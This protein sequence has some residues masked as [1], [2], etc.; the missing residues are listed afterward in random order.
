MAVGTERCTR[1]TPPSLNHHTRVFVH[2]YRG[3]REIRVGLDALYEHHDISISFLDSARAKSMLQTG[4][5]YNLK[6]SHCEIH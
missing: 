1:T 6:I 4:C 2:F 5:P 3:Y